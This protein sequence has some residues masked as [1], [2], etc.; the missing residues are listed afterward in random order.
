MYCYLIASAHFFKPLRA[1]SYSSVKYGHRSMSECC[2]ENR[3]RRDNVGS[4]LVR[5]S[6]G[7]G[8]LSFLCRCKNKFGSA[9]VIWEFWVFLFCWTLK[10]YKASF[11]FDSGWSI[12]QSPIHSS[13]IAA[14]GTLISTSKGKLLEIDSG[15]GEKTQGFF[16]QMVQVRLTSGWIYFPQLLWLWVI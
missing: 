14:E 3:I 12:L 4:C 10:S 2:W 9:E 15:V 5:Q 13:C 16:L 7:L 1:L 11:V 8:L 6:G